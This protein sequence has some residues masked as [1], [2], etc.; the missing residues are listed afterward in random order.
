MTEPNWWES[1]MAGIRREAGSKW[2][3]LLRDDTAWTKIATGDF[4]GEWAMCWGD[5]GSQCKFNM[6]S[7]VEKPQAKNLG[8]L[9]LHRLIF[10]RYIPSWACKANNGSFLSR[11]CSL[12]SQCVS[13]G[14]FVRP[15]YPLNFDLVSFMSRPHVASQAASETS[16]PALD[17]QGISASEDGG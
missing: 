4:Y 14:R 11:I 5:L 15:F 1:Q 10:Q 12:R 8:M 6:S 2:A 9:W 7:M 13:K 3:L 16:N 17:E